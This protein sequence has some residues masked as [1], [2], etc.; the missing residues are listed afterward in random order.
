MYEP[1]KIN[2][3]LDKTHSG[4]YEYSGFSAYN[5]K[6]KIASYCAY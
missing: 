6:I 5:G 4:D 2:I 1:G 3:G